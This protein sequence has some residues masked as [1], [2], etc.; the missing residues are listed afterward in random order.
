MKVLINHVDIAPTTLGLCGISKPEW[1]DGNDYS[2][3]RLEGRPSPNL[4][5]S[6]YLQNVVVTGHPD[7]VDREWRGIVTDDGWKYVALEDNPWRMFNLNDD[8][9][10]QMNLAHNTKYAHQRKRLHD[11]LQKWIAET[12]DNFNLFKL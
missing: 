4:P 6:A 8:P 2:G 3:L 12:G 7:S 10:E 9:F 1:M 11:R 5:D